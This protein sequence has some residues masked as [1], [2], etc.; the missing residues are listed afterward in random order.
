MKVKITFIG[1]IGFITALI[2]TA[3]GSG[4]TSTNGA[5]SVVS[6]S[7]VGVPITST[8]V[9]T[10]Y[11]QV[12]NIFVSIDTSNPESTGV[13]PYLVIPDNANSTTQYTPQSLTYNIESYFQFGN[14]M[15][16][17]AGLVYLPV[18]ESGNT[19]YSL[20]SYRNNTF[21]SAA[22]Y[23][24]AAW[25]RPI[26]FGAF[27]NANL[28]IDLDDGSGSNGDLGDIPLIGG[29]ASVYSGLFPTWYNGEY[30]VNNGNLY[31][32]NNNAVY[33]T[34]ISSAESSQVGISFD[35]IPNGIT[36]IP[37]MLDLYQG[38]IYMGVTYSKGQ[39]SYLAV[40]KISATATSTSAWSC[41]YDPNTPMV[42]AQNITS[43]RVGQSSGNIIV[44]V[45]NYITATTQLYLL[46][47]A[48]VAK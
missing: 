3:C 9:T 16:N 17:D 29:R 25:I 39:N 31:Y 34:V 1:L 44:S 27:D 43:F 24:I 11:A 4:N 35:Q 28:Y 15:V 30:A 32:S 20:L 22:N 18:M 19:G 2:I 5:P 33:A 10:I 8:E 12:H 46:S 36:A 7:K 41:S 42:N 48:S 21:E 38:N 13:V 26:I 47:S 23:S 40:C 45:N 37:G 6:F 14:I